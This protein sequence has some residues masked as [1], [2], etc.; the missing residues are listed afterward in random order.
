MEAWENP[1][2]RMNLVRIEREKLNFDSDVKTNAQM[3]AKAGAI[4][5]ALLGLLTLCIG[6]SGLTA[7]SCMMTK[8]RTQA[9]PRVNGG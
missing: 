9:V 8:H 2:P 4:T 7:W 3:L 1:R 5:V 6:F